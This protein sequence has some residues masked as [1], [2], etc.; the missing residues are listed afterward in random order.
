MS[1]STNI[2]VKVKAIF[3]P[4]TCCTYQDKEIEIND[5]ATIMD[6]LDKISI[7]PELVMAFV[8]NGRHE[9]KDYLLKNKD[10]LLLLSFIGGG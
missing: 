4:V 6:L 10:D 2:K 5:G 9:K 3:S 8:V 1:D 7:R